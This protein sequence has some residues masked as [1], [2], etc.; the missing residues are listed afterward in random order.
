ML[1]P[2]CLGDGCKECSKGFIRQT[3]RPGAL[4]S[5]EGRDLFDAYCWL[6]NYGVLPT[7]GGFLDQPAA[8]LDAVEWCDGVHSAYARVRARKNEE[9]AKLQASLR[10]LMGNNAGR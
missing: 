3:V 1:C 6:K 4:L 2:A 5:A 9:T 8:F 7:P 10:K